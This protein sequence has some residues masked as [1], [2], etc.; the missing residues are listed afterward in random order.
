MPDR[1]ANI[2]LGLDFQT[3]HKRVILEYGGT[4]PPLVP[5]AVT[6]AK[7]E[8]HVN[9]PLPSMEVDLI[10]PFTNLSPDCKPIATKSRRYSADDRHFITG[11]VR[12][13]V[14]QSII[15]PSNS[16]WQAQVL[17]KN[18]NHKKRLV[19]DGPNRSCLFAAGSSTDTIDGQNI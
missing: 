3:K 5:Y 1:C 9:E 8:Q 18:E 11:E 19:I 13:L 4:L 16:P 6:H 14:K 10:Q 15:E 12:C 2:L 17:V 7:M